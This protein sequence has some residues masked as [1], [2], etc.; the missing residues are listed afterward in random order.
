MKYKILQ[1]RKILIVLTLISGLCSVGI[2]IA[3]N[4]P[5]PPDET[6]LDLYFRAFR[7]YENGNFP[8]CISLTDTLQKGNP[9]FFQAGL[10]KAKAEFFSDNFEASGR[11][12]ENLL[13]R[14]TNYYEAEIWILRCYLQLG[15][16]EKAYIKAEE[17]HSR[18]PEDPRILNILGRIA[19]AEKNYQEAIEFFNRA[20]LFEEE[21]A[22]NRI[23]LAKL[24]SELLNTELAAANFKQ[25]DN[26]LA[27]D[28]PIKSA[29]SELI[30]GTENQ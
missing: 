22:V 4:R 23:E 12:L 24:Y 1:N 19:A 26:L 16:T 15:E 3:L 27:P 28:S 29:V 11:T 30:S 14:N 5:S 2:Y 20:A 18:S 6:E 21:L 25:A 17:L 8:L 9:S 13:K 7:A 10:L